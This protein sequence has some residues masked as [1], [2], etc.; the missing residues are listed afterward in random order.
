MRHRDGEGVLV[1]SLTPLTYE[2]VRRILK[3]KFECRGVSA[4]LAELVHVK[5]RGLPRFLEE[6]LKIL[7]ETHIIELRK[8]ELRLVL[9]AEQ[10]GKGGPVTGIGAGGGLDGRDGRIMNDLPDSL[11]KLVQARL[12]H[13]PPA[14]QLLMKVSTGWMYQLTVRSSILLPLRA[15]HC[16]VCFDAGG[17][18][19]VAR[20]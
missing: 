5:C 16:W 8:G 3:M 1:C 4:G 14:L 12:D 2:Q 20:T 13:L 9:G 11:P 6:L 19:F 7:V 10:R 18:S 15:Y 17:F